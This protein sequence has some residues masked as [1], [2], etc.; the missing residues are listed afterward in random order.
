[1]RARRDLDADPL[2]RA[3]ALA[4][5]RYRRLE[6]KFRFYAHFKYRLDPVYRSLIAHLPPGS[7]TV[8][9]GTGLGMLPVLLGVLGEERRALGVEWDAAKARGGAEA[10]RDLPDIQIVEGDVRGF[11]IPTCDRITLVDVLHYYEAESQRA[12]LARC[13]AALRPGGALLIRE[14]DR[15][16][17]GGARFTRFVERAVTKLGWNRGPQVRFRP[18]AELA[19]DLEALGFVVATDEVAGRLHPG[20]VLLSARWEATG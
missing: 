2:Q 14:G 11:A 16:R 6:R 5:A 18:I 9:L 4:S 13:R 3:I 10:A 17:Q 19:R 1:V 7:F 12:L 8:D 15:A 20:N